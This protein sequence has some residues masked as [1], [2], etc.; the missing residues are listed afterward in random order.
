MAV[1]FSIR[2]LAQMKAKFAR[3]ATNAK[4]VM[5]K[6][7]L[8]FGTLVM[9][10]AKERYVPVDHDVLRSS[11]KVE[12][13]TDAGW[14]NTMAVRLS[15]GGPA[16]SYAI[17]VHEHLSD[18]SPATWQDKTD[19]NWTKAGTGPKYLEMPVMWHSKDLHVVA[20]N[21]WVHLWTGPEQIA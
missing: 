20:S 9:N 4:P 12:I 13:V 19:L 3:A 15:F 10:D 6:D 2:G 17:A 1:Q 16:A 18:F 11:G 14:S 7:L 21:V 5:E 8:R